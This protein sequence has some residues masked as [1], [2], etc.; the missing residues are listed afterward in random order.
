M[1]MD[2]SVVHVHEAD[3]A[4]K[5]HLL[6]R[7][8]A[9]PLLLLTIAT[10]LL[11]VLGTD[12]TYFF[13]IYLVAIVPYLEFMRRLFRRN[14]SAH[15]LELAFIFVW[16]LILRLTFLRL[17]PVLSTDVLQYGI[18]EQFLR[19]GSSPYTGFFFPYPAVFAYVLKLFEM[20]SV[21]PSEFRVL[22]VAFDLVVAFLLMRIAADL[23]H[24]EIGVVAGIGYLFLPSAI[25]ESGWNGHFEPMVNTLA[26]LAIIL[27]KR[28]RPEMAGVANGLAIGLKIYPALFVVAG[29]VLLKSARTRMRFVLSVVGTMIFS[30]APLVYF[31]GYSGLVEMIRDLGV[32]PSGNGGSGEAL[33][34][35]G[36][37]QYLA[38]YSVLLVQRLQMVSISIVIVSFIAILV[39]KKAGK[40][41]LLALVL[42]CWLVGLSG[43]YGYLRLTSIPIFGAPVL[44]Y[45]FVPPALSYSIG[46]LFGVTT[47]LL[48]MTAR[49]V[50]REKSSM[51]LK[52]LV[53]SIGAAI[54]VMNFAILEGWYVF[55]FV[56]LIFLLA[57]RRYVLPLL[58]LSLV[59]YASPLTSSNFQ[60]IGALGETQYVSPANL[61]ASSIMN[62]LGPDL[63]T[64]GIPVSWARSKLLA[65]EGT[66]VV[67]NQTACFQTNPQFK[68]SY[69]YYSLGNYVDQ[70]RYPYLF[71]KGNSSLRALRVEFWNKS[72]ILARWVPKSGDS[73]SDYVDTMALTQGQIFDTIGIVDFQSSKVCLVQFE[74]IGRNQASILIG[75]TSLGMKIRATDPTAYG[76]TSYGYAALVV[77]FDITRTISSSDI[78]TLSLKTNRDPTFGHDILVEVD[79]ALS[80]VLFCFLQTPTIVTLTRDSIAFNN[81]SWTPYSLSL[82]SLAG[83]EIL[84]VIIKGFPL[85]PTHSE[86]VVSLDLVQ[87][88]SYSDY[89]VL[90]ILSLGVAVASLTI[91]QRDRDVEEHGSHQ[92]FSRK[93]RIDDLLAS[94]KGQVRPLI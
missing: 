61:H 59:L 7:E 62:Q 11:S 56:P 63:S 84:A 69:Y 79:L 9:I 66:A 38:P 8:T 51:H 90:P 94:I 3:P 57:P 89:I 21:S 80:G 86:Y 83:S 4:N 65:H 25:I 12:M 31:T 41:N 55:F 35:G 42:C 70:V 73:E 30:V 75:E 92:A 2:R 68:D 93:R 37:G 20:I 39:A 71:I 45:W 16:G 36:I 5:A 29:L 82:S 24:P 77:P 40:R 60:S 53:L 19:D 85:R 49:L 64:P 17:P 81:R 76:G 54:V 44:Y 34:L 78:L 26:L 91:L 1:A 72:S 13:I 48:V 33:Y 10:S 6:L 50:C 22:M 87:F 58:L 74:F 18:F 32:I 88:S 52:L 23:G 67:N 14:W 47:C 27:T 46:L 28:Q 43:L 15:K